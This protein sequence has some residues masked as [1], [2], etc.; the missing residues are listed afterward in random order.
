MSL[1]RINRSP[2]QGQLTVFGLAW[3]VVLAVL[4]WRARSRG[5]ESWAEALG[6]LAVGV[7]AAGLVNRNLLRLAYLALAYATYPIGFAVSRA[8]L[9]VIYYLAL[10]PIGLT[11][12]LFRYDP[13]SRRFDPKAQSYWIRRDRSKPSESYFNQS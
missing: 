4:G 3:F 5:H 11:M 9:S 12:R 7:P 6:C 1:V 8:L 2:T 13:L 10:T